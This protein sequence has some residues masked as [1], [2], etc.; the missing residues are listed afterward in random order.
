ME[1]ETLMADNGEELRRARSRLSGM[2]ARRRLK[3]TPNTKRH[4]LIERSLELGLEAAPSVNDRR[5][6]LF[7][8]GWTHSSPGSTP[9]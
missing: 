4:A 9:S 1:E 3:D 6:S 7:S 8:G 5:I 2:R